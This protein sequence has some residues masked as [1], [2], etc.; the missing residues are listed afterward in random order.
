MIKQILLGESENIIN[1][2]EALGNLQGLPIQWVRKLTG[3]YGLAGSESEVV[4]LGTFQISDKTTRA[5]NL[6]KL[7]NGAVQ[8]LKANPN[9]QQ[10]IVGFFIKTPV[11]VGK[12]AI[13]PVVLI[14]YQPDYED[15]GQF[16]V[17]SAEGE[18]VTRLE[19]KPSDRYGYRRNRDIRKKDLT[20]TQVTALLPTDVTLE[21]YAVYEDLARKEKKMART[22]AKDFSPTGDI[23]QI[24]HEAS[25]K[26]IQEL[27]EKLKERL[28]K[29]LQIIQKKLETIPDTLEKAMANRL[30]YEDVRAYENNVRK[31][32]NALERIRSLADSLR[33]VQGLTSIADRTTYGS[34]EGQ[35]EL[36]GYFKRFKST[37][38]DLDNLNDFFNEGN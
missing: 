23:E 7:L 15:A 29:A 38:E 5:N 1:V 34:R 4:K 6:I 12:P 11:E 21:L 28:P 10:E 14:K 30:E 31:V 33:D 18:D 3:D 19:G 22:V 8:K 20:L 16:E 37:V 2:A 35:R 25:Q 26:I 9:T 27:I 36:E 32:T 17:V 13:N 24:T